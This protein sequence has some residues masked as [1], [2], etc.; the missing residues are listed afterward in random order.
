MPDGLLDIYGY[1]LSTTIIGNSTQAKIQL[2]AAENGGSAQ[3]SGDIWY[4]TGWDAAKRS[5]NKIWHSNNDGH[6]SGLDADMLDG[7]HSSSFMRADA[8]ATTTGNLQVA[9]GGL[10]NAEIAIGNGLATG[11]QSLKFRTTGV[12]G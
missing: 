5:W 9:S 1:G 8:N 4:R 6:N 10:A 11:T 2:Y 7:V 12:E 3:L